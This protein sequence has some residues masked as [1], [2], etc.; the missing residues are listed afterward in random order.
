M[1][2][3]WLSQS[4]DKCETITNVKGSNKLLMTHSMVKP[5]AL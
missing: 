3:L 5:N 1:I 2:E 4:Q